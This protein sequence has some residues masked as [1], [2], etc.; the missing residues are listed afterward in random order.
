MDLQTLR[1]SAAHIL[2]Q[3]VKEL[4]PETKLAIGPAI[5]DGFYY[6]FDRKLPFKP[7]DLVRIEEKMKKIIAADLVFKHSELPKKKAIQLFKR[8]KEDYK[9]ELINEISSDKVSI[10]Q[11]GNFIDLCRGPHLKSTGQIKA[12]KLLNVAGAYWRGSESNPMLQRIYGTAF[13][14]EQELNRY[15]VNLEKAKL[16]DHRKL[17][18]DLELFSFHS[19]GPGFPFY[20]PKGVILYQ[21]LLDFWKQEHKKRGYLEIKT[22]L[23]LREE[24]WKQ[25]GHFEHY[26]EHMYFTTMG[27]EKFALRP[28]NCPGGLLLYKEKLHSYREFPMRMAELGLVHRHELSGVLHGLF[29]VKAFVIDDAHIFCM[30]SQITAEVIEVTNLILYIY[31]VTGFKDYNIELSTRPQ[32]SMGSEQMWEEATNALKDALASLKIEYKVNEGEGAFY[33]PKIDFHIRDCLGRMWQCG[34]I[35]VD[36]SMPEKFNLEYIG[37]DAKSHRPVMIHRAAFGSVE[38]FIGILIE[39]YGGALPTWLSPEQ[40]KVIT[41]AERH[42]EYAKKVVSEMETG[43]IRVGSD[44]RNEKIS[45][46][47]REAEVQKIP[48]MTVI[49]DREVENKSISVR[50]RSGGDQGGQKLSEFIKKIKK[51]ISEHVT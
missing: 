44:F 35:Q 9:L 20:H 39:H 47:I 27:E 3:A 51:E 28:M 23:V 48:Y 25:S 19:E 14:T 11:Q 29:R 50:S 38:R 10:Y 8:L 36:F 5:S 43:D 37:R 33:G 15:L 24:L 13:E 2:A 22:P 42:I 46:K 32:D 6:D 45:Y 18:K 49:G 4:Y 40:V 16:R 1:H 21:T 17:G 31:K 12:F 41:I 34:T 26:R 30:P 7:E